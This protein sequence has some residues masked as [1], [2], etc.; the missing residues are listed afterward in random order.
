MSMLYISTPPNICTYMVRN[1]ICRAKIV[2]NQTHNVKKP[3]VLF[4]CLGY[5]S[6]VFLHV[7]TFMIFVWV[8]GH[9]Y[10]FCVGVWSFV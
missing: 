6:P 7:I 9:L 4:G 3:V 2:G 5:G 10:D 1:H 8:S